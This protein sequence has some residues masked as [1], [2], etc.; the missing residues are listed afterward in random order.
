[1]AFSE[2]A[3]L[4]AANL[5]EKMSQEGESLAK[6]GGACALVRNACVEGKTIGGHPVRLRQ[7]IQVR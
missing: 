1:M 6:A 5:V 2:G 4:L 3:L 7:M